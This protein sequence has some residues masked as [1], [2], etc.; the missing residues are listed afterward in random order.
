MTG[1][2]PNGVG[3]VVGNEKT[4]IP[5]EGL[6]IPN[7]YPNMDGALP[8]ASGAQLIGKFRHDPPPNP[9]ERL[10]ARF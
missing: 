10:S 9:Q 7:G 8:G 5:V 6:S 4:G 3:R 2:G 1:I